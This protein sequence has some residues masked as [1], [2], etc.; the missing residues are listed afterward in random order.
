MS[1]TTILIVN[2]ITFICIFLLSFW[3]CKNKEYSDCIRLSW[4][5]PFATTYPLAIASGILLSLKSTDISLYWYFAT[6]FLVTW[7]ST[8][9]GAEFGYR[10]YQQKSLVREIAERVNHKIKIIK[11]RFRFLI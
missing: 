2:A 6:V 11:N 4:A 9:L 1:A 3:E 7:I 8:P 10:H 5:I